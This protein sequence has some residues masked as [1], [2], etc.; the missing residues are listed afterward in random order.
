MRRW[1]PWRRG[2]C[3]T[4]GCQLRSR[5][6]NTRTLSLACSE[7]KDAR[8]VKR[9]RVISEKPGALTMLPNRGKV[10]LLVSQGR[11]H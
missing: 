1:I 3:L 5:W 8:T 2:Y 6:L 4:P 10:N 9:G 11:R 7:H